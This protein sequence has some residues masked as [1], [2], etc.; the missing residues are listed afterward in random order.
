MRIAVLVFGSRVS[1]RFDMAQ[2]VLLFERSASGTAARR[3]PVGHWHPAERIERLA[4]L[5]VT[6][7][8]CGAIRGMHAR[9]LAARNI[10]VYSWVTGEAEH[11]VECLL[12]GQLE[13]GVMTGPSGLCGRWR[14]RGAGRRGRGGR[15]CLPGRP[16]EPRGGRIG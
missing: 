15:G 8:I 3:I 4:A 10:R 11:A 1:P 14:F 9:G 16:E 5:R 12:A 6:A 13:S 7:V 2:E